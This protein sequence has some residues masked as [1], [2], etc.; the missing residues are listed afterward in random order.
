[1]TTI[2]RFD[3]IKARAEAATG[4]PWCWFGNTDM[5]NIYLATMHS[6]RQLVLDFARWGKSARPR[7]NEYGLMVDADDRARYEVA[8]NATSRKDS[9]VYR[10]DITGIGHPDAEFI[11]H[12][13]ADVEWLIGEVKRLRAL[14]GEERAA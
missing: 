8:P 4:G 12:S 5:H 13:R 14:V 3:E 11:A 1:M 6:G 10:A 9:A 2:D 7:F